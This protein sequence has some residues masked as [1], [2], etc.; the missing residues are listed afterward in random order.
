MTNEQAVDDYWSKLKLNPYKMDRDELISLIEDLVHDL[1]KAN[2]LYI[3]S[4]NKNQVLDNK[5]RH[6]QD[7]IKHKYELTI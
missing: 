3:S 6:L 1:Q 2:D 4:D 5:I 7:F